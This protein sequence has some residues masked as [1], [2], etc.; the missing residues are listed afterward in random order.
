[1]P[2]TGVESGRARF[3]QPRGRRGRRGRVPHLSKMTRNVMHYLASLGRRAFVYQVGHVV[4]RR[5]GRRLA[6]EAGLEVDAQETRVRRGEEVE[7]RISIS[8]PRAIGDLKVGVRCTELYDEDVSEDTG[9]TSS[10]RMPSTRRKTFEAIAY[11]TWVPVDAVPGEQS[12]RI[13]IPEDAPFSYAGDCLSFK[14][15]VVAREVRRHAVD[16][17]A[18]GELRVLP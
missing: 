14:W 3:C 13:A 12:A 10:T 15:E 2:E 16:A 4:L 1:V 7:A 18:T 9:G 5:R 6:T 11:E 17:E 8:A